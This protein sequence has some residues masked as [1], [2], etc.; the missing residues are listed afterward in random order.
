MRNEA[1]ER[2]GVLVGRWKLTMTNSWFMPSMDAEVY[3]SATVEWLDDAFLVLRSTF[4]TE[5]DSTWVMGRSDAN[6]R[7][8]LLYHDQRERES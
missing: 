6:D 8:V 4:G 3:G 2:L 7:Y 5:R 1:M